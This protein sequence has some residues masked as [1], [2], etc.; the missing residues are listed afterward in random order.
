MAG[1]V[2]VLGALLSAVFRGPGDG[3]AI[4]V[5]GVVAFVV[6]CAAF[7]LSRMV[8]AGNLAARLGAGALIRFL[9]LVVY[10]ALVVLVLKLPATAALVSLAAFFFVSTLIEPLLIK[11]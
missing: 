1:I 6:Q 2:V 5:S 9:T 4:W 8:G 11:S 7:A 10:A 3:Q